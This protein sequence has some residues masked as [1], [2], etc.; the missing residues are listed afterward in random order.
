M[1]SCGIAV[2]CNSR[3]FLPISGNEVIEGCPVPHIESVK[4]SRIQRPDP[5]LISAMLPH[6]IG[7]DVASGSLQ[8]AQNAS[9]RRLS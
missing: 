5:S 6:R 7:R 9:D 8:P 4:E 1:H 3:S 2:H